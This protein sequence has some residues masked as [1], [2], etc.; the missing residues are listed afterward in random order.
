LAA[1]GRVRP[2]RNL[3]ALD[4][5]TGAQIWSHRVSDYTGIVGDYARTTPA[6]K[7]NSLIFGDQGGK[8]DK[9]SAWVMAVDKGTGKLLWK[10]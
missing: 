8:F 7:G 1:A 6:I 4:R 2:A 5:N 3:F 10:T 9:S